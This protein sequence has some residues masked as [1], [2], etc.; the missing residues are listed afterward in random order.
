LGLD[1]LPD[2][3]ARFRKALRLADE[4]Q[5]PQTTADCILGLAAV[6]VR[7]GDPSRAGVLL[8]AADAMFEDAG[9]EL[10]PI[11]RTI[12]HDAVAGI[13][14]R[15]GEDAAAKALAMGRSLSRGDALA[16]AWSDGD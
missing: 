9:V 11:E 4:L 16:H 6:L 14:A 13:Q 10:S 5:R 2:A 7:D 1:R 3:A 8:G 12:R 15:I